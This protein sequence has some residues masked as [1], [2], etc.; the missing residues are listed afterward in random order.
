MKKYKRRPVLTAK[1]RLNDQ[2]IREHEEKHKEESFGELIEDFESQNEE[3]MEDT[4]EKSLPVEEQTN[5]SLISRYNVC[6][7]KNLQ[8]NRTIEDPRSSKN[9]T[10]WKRMKFKEV[11]EDKV[12]LCNRLLY[13]KQI[14]I[15]KEPVKE[16]DITLMVISTRKEFGWRIIR[17]QFIDIAVKLQDFDLQIGEI[18]TVTVI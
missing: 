16:E 9:G 8:L 15:E 13:A 5:S 3:D 14:V 2:H 12:S 7:I 10:S 1:L 11:S 6:Q 17:T 4:I 18:I